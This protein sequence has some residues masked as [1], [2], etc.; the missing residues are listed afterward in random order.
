MENMENMGKI[1]NTHTISAEDAERIA[2]SLAAALEVRKQR[3]ERAVIHSFARQNNLTPE[4]L[5]E[6]LRQRE[7]KRGESIPADIQTAIDSRIKA[8]NDRLI[9][10]EIRNVGAQL[11]LV[12]PEA[13]FALMDRS[14]VFIDDDGSVRGVR[15]SLA[16]LLRNKPYLAS[17]S[18]ST[19]RAGNFP[20]GTDPSDYASRLAAA[21]SSGDNS[22]AAALIAEAAANGIQLR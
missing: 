20:R 13:A 8:A 5:G 11:G 17:P 4:V 1:Q 14:R 21:R 15:E 22:L 19:G 9:S 10:A 7:E 2:D 16:E 6:F 3:A 12:D 18:L